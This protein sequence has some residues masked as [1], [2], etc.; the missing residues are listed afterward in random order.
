MALT[1]TDE[2]IAQLRWGDAETTKYQSQLPGYIDAASEI[3]EA[4][5]GPFEERTVVHI[6]DG[7]PS[8]QLPLRVNSVTQVQIASDAG[9]GDWVDGYFVPSDGWAAVSDWTVDLNAGII[10]GPFERGRQN[11]RVTYE[12]G[13]ETIPAS[14]TFAT[15]ALVAHMW[16]I[17]SQ[18]GPGL[19]E[20]YTSVPTGFLVPNVVKEALAQYRTMPGFA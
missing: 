3:I 7:G 19:P 6:A 1:T 2:V 8:I 4:E 9:G 5:A 15:T 10:Y 18:R 12:V 11:V 17:A 13:M 14:V 16:A 20:D